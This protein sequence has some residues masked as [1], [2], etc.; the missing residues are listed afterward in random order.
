MRWRRAS[1]D[2]CWL[3]TGR[4]SS[5]SSRKTWS[6]LTPV[7]DSQSPPSSTS[8][9]GMW[10]RLSGRREVTGQARWGSCWGHAFGLPQGVGEVP[11]EGWGLPH[12]PEPPA[13]GNPQGQRRQHQAKLNI[14]GNTKWR[15]PID[16]RPSPWQLPQLAKVIALLSS[17]L[18]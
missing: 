17:L 4:T 10:S 5:T 13:D 7:M 18:L 8:S 9:T 12:L 2:Q 15:S 6:L 3:L 16:N 14:P 1:L 11:S